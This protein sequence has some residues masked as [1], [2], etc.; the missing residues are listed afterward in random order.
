MPRILVSYDLGGPESGFDYSR[1][2]TRLQQVGAPQ[3][4]LESVWIVDTHMSVK[5]LRD[6]LVP[7]VDANDRLLLIRVGGD[8]WAVHNFSGPPYGWILSS[9]SWL[10]NTQREGVLFP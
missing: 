8:E 7:L 6:D 9:S 10:S 3:R 5:A 2:R 1:L 4:M